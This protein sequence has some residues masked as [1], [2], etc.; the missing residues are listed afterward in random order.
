MSPAR[1]GRLSPEAVRAIYVSR[2]PRGVLAARYGTSAS[3]VANIRSG[4][5]Y[6]DD[7]AQLATSPGAAERHNREV[8]ALRRRHERERRAAHSSVR[9]ALA[10]AHIRERMALAEKYNDD[11][12]CG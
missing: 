6:T 3:M 11:L 7:T 8:Y 4:L 9:E 5:C 12:T 1:A 2:E 10:V